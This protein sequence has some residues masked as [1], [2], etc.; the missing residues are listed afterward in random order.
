MTF[1]LLQYFHFQ[2][3]SLE[4]TQRW[5]QT[6]RQKWVSEHNYISKKTRNHLSNPQWRVSYANYGIT[7]SS[8][9]DLVEKWLMTSEKADE[10]HYIL[11]S[12]I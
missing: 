5:K 10:S 1:P 6:G 3:L 8:I 11:K 2:E 12:R 4:K 9:N 7:G